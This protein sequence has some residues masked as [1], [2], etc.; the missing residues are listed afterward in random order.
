MFFQETYISVDAEIWCRNGEKKDPNVEWKTW[1]AKKPRK[2]EKIYEGSWMD[3]AARSILRNSERLMYRRIWI[4]LCLQ[5][6]THVLHMFWSEKWKATNTEDR[7][8]KQ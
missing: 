7:K 5:V 2:L 1:S 6:R 4:Y 3:E 8:T